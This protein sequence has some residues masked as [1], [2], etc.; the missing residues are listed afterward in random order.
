MK[1][2]ERPDTCK[3]DKKNGSVV[4][5]W[6]PN[7]KRNGEYHTR[8]GICWPMRDQT[9]SIA[10]GAA[11]VCVE[12][13]ETNV[14]SLMEETHFVSIEPYLLDGVVHSGLCAFTNMAF[15][16]YLVDIYYH[17]QPIDMNLSYA[18]QIH[19]SR[20]YGRN[21]FFVHVD[22]DNDDQAES[23]LATLSFMDRFRFRKAGLFAKDMERYVAQPAALL[24]VRMAMIACLNGMNR[25]PWRKPEEE[26]LSA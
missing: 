9:T 16:H 20:M 1:E 25:F 26:E 11:V 18:T 22:W 13:L 3:W 24:P 5:Y 14:V 8:G 4:L 19:R 15:A 12:H 10:R 6:K 17:H 23:V 21:P 2:I 7:D